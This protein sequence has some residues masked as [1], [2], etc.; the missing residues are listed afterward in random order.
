M[1]MKNSN[2]TI[3]NRTRD[4]QACSAVP[5]PTAPPRN[6]DFV[7]VMF[8]KFK[9]IL[10]FN[11]TFDLLWTGYGSSVSSVLSLGFRELKKDREAWQQSITTLRHNP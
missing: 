8:T 2:D 9:Q 7:H 4:L 6:P 3:G 1:S 11:F 5:Q 10:V